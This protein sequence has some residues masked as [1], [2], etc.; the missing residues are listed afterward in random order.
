[1]AAKTISSILKELRSLQYDFRPQAGARKLEILGTFANRRL[2]TAEEVLELHELLC[3]FRAFPGNAEIL[4]AAEKL[5]LEFHLRSDLRRF[6]RQLADTGIAGTLLHFQFYWLTAIWLARRWSGNLTVQWKSFKN[7]E[8]LVDL[9]HLLLPPVDS[10]ALDAQNLEPREWVEAFKKPEETDAGFLIRRFEALRVR[11]PLREKLYEDLDIPMTLSPGP[12]TPARGRERWPAAP[13]VFQKQP[14][15]RS[16]PNLRREVP[17]VSFRVRSVQPRQARRL[18]DLANGCMVPRHRDLL[19]FL[20]ADRRDVRLIDFGDGLQFACMGGVPDR[21]LLLEAVYGFL[22]LMNGVPIGYVL[23]SAFF[24]SA[25]IAY[26]VFETY[27]GAGA[28]QIYARVLGMVQQLFG[29]SSFAI[30]PYQLGHDN[31]E[32]QESGAWWFYYK[33]GFRPRD[34]DVRKLARSEL[35]KQARNRRHRTSPAQLHRLAA[36]YMFL[37][38]GRRRRDVL[39]CISL[40]NIGLHISNYLAA[41]FGSDREKGLD[42]CE[43]ETAAMLGLRS[44][45]ALPPGERLAWRRWAPVVLALPG[46]ERWTAAQKKALREVVRAKGGRRESDFVRLF[47]RHSRL[48]AAVMELSDTP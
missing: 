26:N 16:R 31:E 8:K 41:R 23:C 37:Q 30:D 13:V 18:I 39:G 15:S 20:H 47:D 2:A 44:L 46:V 22:T 32:G 19:A 9:L 40:G 1:M 29:V 17:K 28:A 4:A 42:V 25:E 48:R 11:T 33:L 35:R 24:N 5:C 45:Q 36:E 7:K 21:R 27:R 34:P 10:V 12:D 14:P 38:F 43:R 6:R 3:F